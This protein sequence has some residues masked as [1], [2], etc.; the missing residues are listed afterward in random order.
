M[1]KTG[2]VSPPIVSPIWPVFEKE[3]FDDGLVSKYGATIDNAIRNKP[4]EIVT[5]IIEFLLCVFN[6]KTCPLFTLSI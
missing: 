2:A 1:A 3:I 6:G 4:I 5:I